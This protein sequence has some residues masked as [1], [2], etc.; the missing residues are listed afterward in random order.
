[1]SNDIL[2]RNN[3]H[4]E[5]NIER[6]ETIVFAHGFGSD[7]TAWRGVK[8]AFESSYRLVL[9]DNAGAG[10]A[11]P[12]SY[13]PAKYRS[14]QGYALD[15]LEI[16]NTLNLRNAIFVG[17]S[18]SAMI[19]LLSSI[20]AHDVFS[21]LILIGASPRYLNDAGYCGGF[22]KQDLESLYTQMTDGYL[23][24]ASGFSKLAMANHHN[25]DLAA[26]FSK[27]LSAL[28]PDTALQVAKS[29][30]ESDFRSIL[31]QV[32]R[33]VL[34]IRSQTDTVVPE[35]VSI[36]LNQHIRNSRLVTV[37][38]EGHFPHMSAPQEIIKAIRE[39]IK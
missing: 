36:Y 4:V 28:R 6:P 14:L 31:P 13:S 27:S 26:S 37:D 20:S 11:A 22:S 1:M 24:W 30:F 39:F 19:G 2:R 10:Q 8:P 33:E 18:V 15:L 34:L 17:H 25:P 21:K 3:V 35:E 7:Q 12:L 16:A 23:Q 5:G 9:F 32:N 29:I 38:A